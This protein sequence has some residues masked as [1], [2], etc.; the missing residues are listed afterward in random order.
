MRSHRSIRHSSML[1]ILMAIISPIRSSLPIT[2]RVA[3]AHETV[4]HVSQSNGARDHASWCDPDT[5]NRVLDSLD[6]DSSSEP[7]GQ[8]AR[9]DDSGLLYNPSQLSDNHADS[10]SLWANALISEHARFLPS[11]YRDHPHDQGPRRKPQFQDRMLADSSAGHG[12]E[13]AAIRNAEGFPQPPERLY[14]GNFSGSEGVQY[15][16]NSLTDVEAM[17]KLALITAQYDGTQNQQKSLFHYH[18][19]LSAPNV[20]NTLGFHKL[21]FTYHDHPFASWKDP[22]GYRNYPS[23]NSGHPS[24]YLYGPSEIYSNT[25]RNRSG[26]RRA[27]VGN[28]RPRNPNR[29][30]SSHEPEGQKFGSSPGKI[31]EE[32]VHVPDSPLNHDG[33]SKTKT[34][35]QSSVNEVKAQLPEDVKSN[36]RPSR[37]LK[38]PSVMGPGDLEASDKLNH[39]LHLQKED[40]HGSHMEG[41]STNVESNKGSMDDL[42]SGNKQAAVKMTM[43]EITSKT[44]IPSFKDH[45]LPSANDD[46]TPD[47]PLTSNDQSRDLNSSKFA[48]IPKFPSS[49][50]TLQKSISNEVKPQPAE[51]VK[52]NSSTS[53]LAEPPAETG[54]DDFG[55]SENLDPMSHPQDKSEDPHV[56]HGKPLEQ[57]V[58]LPGHGGIIDIL[59]SSQGPSTSAHMKK[60]DEIETPSQTQASDHLPEDK[61]VENKKNITEKSEILKHDKISRNQFKYQANDRTQQN[62]SQKMKK[63]SGQFR[64][65][66][67]EKDSQS[68]L[69]QLKPKSETIDQ[70]LGTESESANKKS[71]RDKSNNRPRKAIKLAKGSTNLRSNSESLDELV[72]DI[73]QAAVKI[74]VK[75][76]QI[77]SAPEPKN[78]SSQDR[79]LPA[80]NHD[81]TPDISVTSN[82]KLMDSNSSKGSPSSPS[83]STPLTQVDVH[84]DKQN[85]KGGNQDQSQTSRNLPAHA[86]TDIEE[87]SLLRRIAMHK[88]TIFH[89]PK[90][91]VQTRYDVGYNGQAQELEL[92]FQKLKN[93]E[94]STSNGPESS[95]M[96]SLKIPPKYLKK[97]VEDAL[98]D[99]FQGIHFRGEPRRSDHKRLHTFAKSTIQ[100]FFEMWGEENVLEWE[101]RKLNMI[102]MARLALEL[103]LDHKEAHYGISP[104]LERT[105]LYDQ[106]TKISPKENAQFT[107]AVQKIL[108]KE[109]ST[110][111]LVAFFHSWRSHNIA[112]KW[113]TFKALWYGSK[114]LTPRQAAQF[115]RRFGLSVD[116]QSL[117]EI[118]RPVKN[119]SKEEKDLIGRIHIGRAI[120]VIYGP[121]EGEKRLKLVE[122]LR[123]RDYRR[124]WW[125]P[126]GLEA[127]SKHFGLDVLKLLKIGDLLQFGSNY[128]LDDVTNRHKIDV[129]YTQLLE[130]VTD[131][132]SVLPWMESPERA[133]LYRTCGALY[134]DR[135]REVS[136]WVFSR[137]GV[138]QPPAT[139]TELIW[140]DLGLDVD[141]LHRMPSATQGGADRFKQIVLNLSDY[142]KKACSVWHRV[143]WPTPLDSPSS[144]YQSFIRELGKWWETWLH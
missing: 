111:R 58:H 16:R 96:K 64:M 9:R 113:K 92:A 51:D 128:L 139:G 68:K 118:P 42:V 114:D 20:R 104:V 97:S 90:V 105:V 129:A 76:R 116:P 15:F 103:N 115:E 65:D 37:W 99:A 3:I 120:A 143:F 72:S 124:E 98:S 7:S 70:G 85:A 93:S 78:P 135:L 101:D 66:H 106:F 53:K 117:T 122:Y 59:H 5:V 24:G 69:P 119:S 6:M 32:N 61:I 74:T 2:T 21:P 49:H 29:K 13:R 22:S 84:V 126:F 1:V 110:R 31:V 10:P 11:A 100:Q 108:G 28:N 67:H 82:E 23:G 33:I 55:A 132:E 43:K 127:A 19:Y 142:E 48:Q 34:H 80:A 62:H 77:P 75:E 35:M 137:G 18:D 14:D 4:P 54:P 123:K 40:L 94:S 39:E 109:E 38:P 26:D 88:S 79:E 30:A 121:S 46:S 144:A 50:G 52:S 60:S 138:A 44:N 95:I 133:W 89:K 131:Q 86:F 136:L 63:T 130:L 12:T 87:S 102:I 81:S 8:D 57:I 45:G 47:I 107:A 36:S 27:K 141:L 41:S 73:K 83:S 112:A 134:Q 140:A 25:S 17:N 56:S 91:Y 125:K 71:I